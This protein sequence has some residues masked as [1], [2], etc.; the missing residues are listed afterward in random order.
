[1]R[2][3][4]AIRSLVAETRLSV[5]DFIAP[6]FIIEGENEISEISSMPGYYRRSLDL[7]VREVEE[8]WSLGL[9]CVLLFVKAKDELKKL[10]PFKK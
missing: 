1:M 10:N 5:D 8:L 2:Q 9:K 4:P 7:A 3:S 6:L